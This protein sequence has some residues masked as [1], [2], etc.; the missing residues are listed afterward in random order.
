MRARMLAMVAVLTVI[1]LASSVGAEGAQGKSGN[2]GGESLAERIS[3][4]VLGI[5]NLTGGIITDYAT[6]GEDNSTEVGRKI[7]Q[8]RT[9]NQLPT[10]EEE[11]PV[12]YYEEDVMV[13]ERAS[14]YRTRA[15][16]ST[17]ES[18]DR[19]IGDARKEGLMRIKASGPV[20]EVISQARNIEGLDD[21]VRETV[22]ARK[23][24]TV[25]VGEPKL[26]P[27][28]IED[29]ANIFVEYTNQLKGDK[30]NI[31]RSGSDKELAA[32]II[33][34]ITNRE[35]SRIRDI[36]AMEYEMNDREA[37]EEI[38]YFSNI[39]EDK[40]PILEESLAKMDPEFKK[41]MAIIGLTGD[42]E[43]QRI[44]RTQVRE[45]VQSR[46]AGDDRIVEAAKKG[47]IDADKIRDLLGSE[48]SAD[49]IFASL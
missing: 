23:T 45:Y 44:L 48:F 3:N 13:V 6:G 10:G 34:T 31:V 21:G 5:I 40:T 29:F 36:E 24:V 39:G 49:M 15:A 20:E 14:M 38:K 4:P 47:G 2:S 41:K 11:E 32:D 1:A 42:A 17:E 46:D 30:K 7:G 33:Q 26:D 19:I 18:E 35:M 43:E 12:E 25:R 16:S 37:T 9:V 27:V 22:M 28:V 8:L